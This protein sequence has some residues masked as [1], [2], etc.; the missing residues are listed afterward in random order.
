MLQKN[1]NVDIIVFPEL[2]TVGYPAED[3][4]LRPSLNKRTQQALEQLASIQ[5][6]RFSVWFCQSN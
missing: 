2:S 5:R 3:L 4:L 1:Q 6:Y